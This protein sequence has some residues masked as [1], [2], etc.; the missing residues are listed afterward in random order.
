MILA[1][2]GI[3]TIE[4]EK[5]DKALIHLCP[6]N[7]DPGKNRSLGRRHESAPPS[8]IEDNKL[9]REVSLRRGCD[10]FVPW[11]SIVFFLGQPFF[12]NPFTFCICLNVSQSNV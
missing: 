7:F 10:A 11:L 8:D 2:R 1:C 6:S 12:L 9:I 4:P 3:S 5:T